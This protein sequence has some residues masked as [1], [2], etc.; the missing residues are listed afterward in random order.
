MFARAFENYIDDKL[1]AMN[2]RNDYL[3]GHSQSYYQVVGDNVIYA[4]PIDKEREF[5]NSC[6]DELILDLKKEGFFKEMA[7]NPK[8]RVKKIMNYVPAIKLREGQK[9]LNF[10]K[11]IEQITFF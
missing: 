2:L 9:P 3:C 10:S 1:I 7:G 4:F 5:I 11:N 8:E 6:F